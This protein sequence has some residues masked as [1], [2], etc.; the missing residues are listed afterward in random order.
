MRKFFNASLSGNFI[1]RYFVTDDLRRIL[2]TNLFYLKFVYYKIKEVDNDLDVQFA[3]QPDV[4]FVY[5]WRCRAMTRFVIQFNLRNQGEGGVGMSKPLGEIVRSVP[6]PVCSPRVIPRPTSGGMEWKWTYHRYDTVSMA[7]TP[8]PKRV[9]AYRSEEDRRSCSRR[10]N[11]RQNRRA[12]VGF[13]VPMLLPDGH[14]GIPKNHLNLARIR[15]HTSS[16]ARSPE[17]PSLRRHLNVKRNKSSAGLHLCC[18]HAF[19]LSSHFRAPT[20]FTDE[21]CVPFQIAPFKLWVF[22]QRRGRVADM[23]LL[24]KRLIFA[25]ETSRVLASKFSKLEPTDVEVWEI[26]HY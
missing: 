8:R 4:D 25:T 15:F 24:M 7:G 17:R 5:R 10:Q 13:Y 12:S 19:E 21:R 1:S 22:E 2:K 6:A 3:C 11:R 26:K 14:P 16:P 9:V 18:S 23:T 20:E